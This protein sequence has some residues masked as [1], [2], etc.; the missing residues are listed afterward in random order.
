MK[1]QFKKKLVLKKQTVS[2]LTDNQM[3]LLRGG[4]IF[5]ICTQSCSIFDL[6]CDTKTNPI[7][8]KRAQD[9][10]L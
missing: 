9:D 6:C 4:T 5:H 3:D 10:T 8:E 2:S 1:K 7:E